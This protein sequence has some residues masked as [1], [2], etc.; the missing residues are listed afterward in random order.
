MQVVLKTLP[1]SKFHILFKDKL[2]RKGRLDDCVPVT[3]ESESNAEEFILE[4]RQDG[5]E[6]NEIRRRSDY[7][8]FLSATNLGVVQGY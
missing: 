8:V 1:H 6:H 5:L 7:Y 4:H 2:L 3:F